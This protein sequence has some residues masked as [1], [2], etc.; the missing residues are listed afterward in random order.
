MVGL[1]ENFINK[2][3]CRYLRKFVFQQR[4]ASIAV[5]NT[6][7]FLEKVRGSCSIYAALPRKLYLEKKKIFDREVSSS[8]KRRGM[9]KQLVNHRSRRLNTHRARNKRL[10]R[11]LA[12]LN[13][14]GEIICGGRNET[15]R[16]NNIVRA[17]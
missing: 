15:P 9:V 10:S 12:F 16:D 17:E 3:D 4:K 1:N 2:R 5:L 13:R 6:E 7:R 14:N 11:V 8:P